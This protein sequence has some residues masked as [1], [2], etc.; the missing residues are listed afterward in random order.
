M[1]ENSVDHLFRHQSGKMVSILTRIFGLTHLETIEDAVQDTFVKAS[2]SWREQKPNNPEAWLMRA[3]KNRVIDLLR[4]LSSE[5]DLYNKL[6]T[7]T[8][9]ISIEKLFLDHEIEDS[10]LRMIFTACHPMLDIRDQIAFSLKLIAG[11]SQKEIASA[12]LIKEETVKKRISRSRK[13]IIDSE[14]KFEFPLGKEL[15]KRLNQVLKV[16]Y[17]IFNE[18]FHSNK[19]DAL[20][21]KELCGEAIRMNKLLLNKDITRSGSSYA[22][23]ALFCYQSARLDSRISENGELI[24]L[25]HQDRSLWHW[26]LIELGNNAMNKSLEMNDFGQ[27]HLEAAIASE[28]LKAMSFEETDWK[29]ILFWYQKYYVILPSDLTLL[30]MAIIKIELKDYENA[31]E[32]LSQINSEKLEQRKYL[33]YGTLAEYYIANKKNEEAIKYMNLSIQYCSNKKEKSFLKR[34]LLSW[35]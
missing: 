15:P 1:Q 31:W 12:L 33:Y 35:Q 19:Q 18:G 11:F 13:K 29:K 2:L 30:N 21:R 25:K 27:Y 5:K 20:I 23:F 7:G 16:L 3:A 6:E 32:D 14:I 34:K 9:A 8:S 24:D 10:Q 26:P 22:L 17:L 28:H 4:K